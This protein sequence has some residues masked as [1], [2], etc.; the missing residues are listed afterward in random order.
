MHY[1]AFTTYLYRLKTNIQ[2]QMSQTKKTQSVILATTKYSF[3]LCMSFF[4]LLGSTTMQLFF[5]QNFFSFEKKCTSEQYDNY[6]KYISNYLLIINILMFI[7]HNCGSLY[8]FFV[9]KWVFLVFK[10]R[11]QCFCSM[12]K[13]SHTM[14]KIFEGYLMKFFKPLDIK[15]CMKK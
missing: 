8:L 12:K 15:V 9:P 5:E 1:W 7:N 14:Q 13:F 10:T 3:S 11:V 2:G 4:Q 6:H